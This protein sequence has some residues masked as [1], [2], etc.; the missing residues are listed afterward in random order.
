MD[1]SSLPEYRG[2]P[3]SDPPAAQDDSPRWSEHGAAIAFLAILALLLL[4][5]LAVMLLGPFL[6]V[7]PQL[8]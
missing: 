5:A 3:D 2:L 1:Y 6:F 8:A 4:L 7:V